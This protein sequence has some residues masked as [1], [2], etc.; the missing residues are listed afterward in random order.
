MKAAPRFELGIKDLQSSA[1]P[2]GH[3]AISEDELP[4]ADRISSTS[5]SLLV[6]SN[7]HG[8][9]LIALRILT[10][11]YKLRPEVS[12]EVMPLVGEGK[13]FVSAISEGWVRQI[14]P[15]TYLP[16]GGF[17]NQSFQGLLADLSSGLL[18]TSLIQWLLVRK[19]AKQGRKIL[20]VGDFFPL[21]YAWSSC[22]D[23]GFIGTPKSDYTWCSGPGKALS[24][25]YHCLKKS[26]WDPW[27][28]TL[29]KSSRCCFVAVRDSLTARGLRRHGVDAQAPGNPMMDDLSRIPVPSALKNYRRLLLLCGSRM[30]E[31]G[32]NFK[33]LLHASEL[34]QSQTPLAFLVALGSEPALELLETQLRARGYCLCQLSY[35]DINAQV[36]FQ[37]NGNLVFLGKGQFSRW[38]SWTEVG[39]AN[40][41]TATEQ[42]VG[43][44]IPALSL[45]GSGPQFKKGFAVRQSRLLGGA[46]TPCETSNEFVEKLGFL[47]SND[48]FRNFQGFLGSR[49][50]G[51][52]GGSVALAKL[53][54]ELLLD[55]EERC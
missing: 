55:H 47:L 41:G 24:D 54:S 35:E 36:C 34:L 10:A 18:G 28:W 15:S 8:E 37:K 46:V 29:M 5:Q 25:Y 13:I 26:E 16:S 11:L 53:V 30:P 45:P 7:G 27:E 20:V 39:I 44:G 49:R 19:A 23:Y 50:M 33:R 32:E 48:S 42:L 14:G 9:D 51:S 52:T 6:L 21:I 4:S 43:L 31:A 40:A 38:A 1:L 3:A 17:S 2:L 22:A 12:Y